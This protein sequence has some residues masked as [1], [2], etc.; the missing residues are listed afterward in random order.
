MIYNLLFPTRG[1]LNQHQHDKHS[2]IMEQERT[3]AKTRNADLDPKIGKVRFRGQELSGLFIVGESWKS[4]LMWCLLSRALVVITSHSVT[5]DSSGLVALIL[6][7]KIHPS[8]PLPPFC[9]P[10]LP[11]GSRC[12]QSPI[13]SVDWGCNVLLLLCIVD[14]WNLYISPWQRLSLLVS[15]NSSGSTLDNFQ[16]GEESFLWGR[17]KQNVRSY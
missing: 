16:I 11:I 6:K 7:Y 15:H 13:F 4:S 3:A 2:D 1:R 9:P 8:Q 10:D 12:Q 17:G 14:S 5:R